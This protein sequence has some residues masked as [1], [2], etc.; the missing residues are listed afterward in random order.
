MNI[1]IVDD[2]KLTINAL[3]H[4]LETMG[5]KTDITQNGEK[6]IQMVNSGNFDLI[7]CDVMMPGIS[8]L[9]LVAVLRTMHLCFTPII[10]MSTLH[11]RPLI[12]A[13]IKAGANEFID[14]PVQAKELEE[15]VKKFDNKVQ[16]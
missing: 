13:A 10:M 9:S 14:K 4:T 15:K 2:D 12:D 5:Y 7:I 6:A 3:Q 11:N 1:L 8:G 16:P